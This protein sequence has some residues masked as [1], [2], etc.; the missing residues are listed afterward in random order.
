[1]AENLYVLG[2]YFNNQTWMNRGIDLSLHMAEKT[3]THPVA[4]A[5]WNY[6]QTIVSSPECD[7]VFSGE[8]ALGLATEFKRKYQGFTT[9]SFA[10]AGTQIPLAENKYSEKENLIYVCINHTCKKPVKTVEEAI[11]QIELLLTK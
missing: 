7:L 9:M 2:R 10:N 3:N 5:S 1:M 11:A 8:R 6:F 4:H